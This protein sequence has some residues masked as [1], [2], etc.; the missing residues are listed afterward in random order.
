MS[1]H[2]IGIEHG[3]KQ[4]QEFRKKVLNDV[5]EH[6]RILEKNLAQH[7]TNRYVS[8]IFIFYLFFTCTVLELDSSETVKNQG[9][10]G[11][12]QFH[13]SFNCSR[14]DKEMKEER[15]MINLKKR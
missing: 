13:S 7:T 14:S 4:L 12:G 6:F 10:G 3:V 2:R 1:F 5:K 11:V 8:S 9:G 15:G